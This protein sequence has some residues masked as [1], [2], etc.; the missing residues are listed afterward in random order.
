MYG[1]CQ[2]CRLPA[3]PVVPGEE[4][5]WCDDHIWK[6]DL[7]RALKL[8]VERAK[9]SLQ[10]DDPSGACSSYHRGE[11]ASLSWV[12]SIIDNLSSVHSVNKE[13]RNAPWRKRAGE[14]ELENNG[15]FQVRINMD[16]GVLW[17]N[18]DKCMLRICRLNGSAVL[19]EGALDIT[20]MPGGIEPS[21]SLIKG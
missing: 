19:S 5:N 21:I 2:V 3:N 6:G 10:E 9:Q 16:K 18:T 15:P 1:K 14:L 17:L 11:I 20:G 12:I 13:K 7:K 4:G 8:A